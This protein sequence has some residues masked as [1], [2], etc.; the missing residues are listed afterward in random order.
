MLRILKYFKWY[1]YIVIILIVLLVYIQVSC[2]LTLA[3]YIQKIVDML[4]AKNTDRNVLGRVA[5][6]MA[7]ISVGSILARASTSYLAVRMAA[8]FSRRLRKMIFEK[9][10]SFSMEEINSFST[11]SLITR[12]TT[13]VQQV[14]QVVMIGLNMAITAPIMA[15][16]GIGMVLG[17]STEITSI[18]AVVLLLLS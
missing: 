11:A 9:V 12:T 7:G 5:L 17:F 3:D 18:I 10:D 2:D 6:E 1:Y 8:D 16:R 13:D 14:Q 15:I 4:L